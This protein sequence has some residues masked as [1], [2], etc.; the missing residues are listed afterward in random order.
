MPSLKD[1]R[2]RISSVK[3]TQ[4]ITR[5]LKLVSAAKL[6]RAQR[7]LG[8][9]KPY[10]EKQQALIRD[11]VAE[12]GGDASPLLATR[13]RVRRVAVL[14]VASD[15]GMCGGFNSNLLKAFARV[16]AEREQRGA[17]VVCYTLG[18]RATQFVEKGKFTL[19]A[20]LG[21]A[22]AADLVERLP[23]VVQGLVGRFLAGELDEVLVVSNRFIN[24]ITQT[25]STQQLLPIQGASAGAA[26]PAGERIYEP[27][28]QQ[29][30][31][32]ILPRSLEIKAR[33]LLLES[34][35]GEHAARMNA[36][37]NATDNAADMI[38]S[39]TLD[40]NRARQAA[41]TTELMEIISGAEALK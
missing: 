20:N 19:E 37:N 2:K 4:K 33:A 34:V 21:E 8:R 15:R 38:Q 24:A 10:A 18:R 7:E 3:N 26:A 16:V 5:A 9:L 31:D 12:L 6:S 28:R 39:L 27:G 30:L 22:L 14:V 17:E 1:I 25:P 32:F 35:T 36:M 41:I 29:L 11:L 13:E 40:L 23:G